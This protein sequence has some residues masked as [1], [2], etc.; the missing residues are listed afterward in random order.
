MDSDQPTSLPDSPS[1]E[2]LYSYIRPLVLQAR[3][4]AYRSSN[5]ILL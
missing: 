3:Q 4:Q 5:A 1:E 2:S